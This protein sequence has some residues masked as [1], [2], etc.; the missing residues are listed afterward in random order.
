MAARWIV[1]VIYLYRPYLRLLVQDRLSEWKPIPESKIT[2]WEALQNHAAIQALPTL[3]WGILL[4]GSLLSCWVVFRWYRRFH[5]INH[6]EYGTAEIATHKEVQKSSAKIPDRLEE[7]PGIGGVPIA[8]DL[9]HNLAGEMLKFRMFKT[10]GSEDRKVIEEKLKKL[11][12]GSGVS[13]SYY[14]VQDTVNSL[15]IGITRSGKGEM[16]VNPLVDI[17]SRAE[18]KGSMVTHD[19]KGEL[20]TMSYETLRKRGYNV[21]VLNLDNMNRSMSYNPLAA[22]IE[23]AKR[24]NIEKTQQYVNS[25]STAIYKKS[26]SEGSSGGNESFWEDSSISL[27]NA[28]ILAL[29]GIANESGDWSKVTLR[30]AVEMLTGMGAQKV[31]VDNN[32]NILSQPDPNAT[33]KSK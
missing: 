29:I 30:N 18:V 17:I 15:V 9:K 12:T 7:F 25:V 10:K 5:V 20:F 4:I 21:Q 3:Y 32:G 14:I 24:G 22:A 6:H 26:K 13:G 19:P 2:S 23:F 1:N 8:H 16:F 27:L 11:P 33:Q 31:Y 28:L